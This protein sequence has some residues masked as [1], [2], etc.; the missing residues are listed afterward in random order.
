MNHLVPLVHYRII[1]HAI[2]GIEQHATHEVVCSVAKLIDQVIYARVNSYGVA[3]VIVGRTAVTAVGRASKGDVL[4][5]S[6][7][8]V[9]LVLCGPG[10]VNPRRASRAGGVA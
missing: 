8:I 2:R 4:Q 9:A 5:T 1:R 3:D 7:Y 10:P 6:L